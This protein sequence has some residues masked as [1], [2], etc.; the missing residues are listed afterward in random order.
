MMKVFK[1]ENPIKNVSNAASYV[2]TPLGKI[3]FDMIINQVFLSTIT[4]KDCFFELI[5]G[6]KLLSYEHRDFIAE[7]VICKP[8]IRLPEH[9]NIDGAFGAVWRVKSI[10]DNL[11]CEF[12]TVLNPKQSI[13]I[14]GGV[15][16]GEGLEGITWNNKECQ[17]SL[18]TQDG[19]TLV[20]RSKINDMMPNYFDAEDEI[21]QHNIVKY[22]KNGV[23]VPIPKMMKDELCQIHFVIAWT[24]YKDEEDCSTWFVV[25][26]DSKKILVNEGLY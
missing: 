22:L 16:S 15:D 11:S 21:S 3:T 2:D 12:H 7:L 5:N 13:D 18:G 20:H 10:L 6:G 24:K 9:M 19:V 23:I 25:D 17:L 14:E 4:T 26:M 8:V 1:A